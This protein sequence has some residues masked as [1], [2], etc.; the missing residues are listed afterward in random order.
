MR[1]ADVADRTHVEEVYQA[2]AARLA[3]QVYALTG[4]FAE[5]QD[6][7]HDAF[8][9]ALAN[10]RR[11]T[12][13]DNPQ[14]WLRTVAVNL[15]RSR[16]RRRKVFDRVVRRLPAEQAVPGVS[17]DHV[18]L[19]RALQRLPRTLREAVVLHHVADLPVTEVAE[20]L[21]CSAGAVKNRLMRGRQQLAA[22]LAEPVKEPDHA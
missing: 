15:A 17:P 16:L 1:G 19:V 5:A 11:F 2:F 7:V 21:G 13:L 8:A 22:Q 12:Q 4:D 20:I 18:E 14:A 10:P 3:A 6:I 9:R